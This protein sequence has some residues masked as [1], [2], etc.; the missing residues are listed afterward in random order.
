MPGNSSFHGR[1]AR[2][3]RLDRKIGAFQIRLPIRN[4][5]LEL[6]LEAQFQTRG[7]LRIHPTNVT[8][9]E[10]IFNSA[11]SP[12]ALAGDFAKQ[13]RGPSRYKSPIP[14]RGASSRPLRVF[15]VRHG[16]RAPVRAPNPRPHGCRKEAR[17]AVKSPD[18][19]SRPKIRPGWLDVNPRTFGGRPT[20][21]HAAMLGMKKLDIAGLKHAFAG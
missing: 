16:C 9:S 6:T 13:G 19:F 21:R 1:L 12:K 10:G 18:T 8:K 17:S 14:R 20:A 5:R 7:K 2:R 11:R 3:A 4:R 15:P